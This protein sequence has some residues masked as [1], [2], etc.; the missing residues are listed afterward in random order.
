MLFLI[1]RKIYL[2]IEFFPNKWLIYF[3]LFNSLWLF[4]LC[5][6]II[7][8]ILIT[9]SIDMFPYKRCAYDVVAF[10]QAVRAMFDPRG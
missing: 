9:F 1:F 6:T 4:D 3:D 10:A 5:I 7:P 2:S 8:S